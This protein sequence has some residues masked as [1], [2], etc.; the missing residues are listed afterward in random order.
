MQENSKLKEFAERCGLELEKAAKET[1]QNVAKALE[2]AEDLGKRAY[3]IIEKE[4][5]TSR[6]EAKNIATDALNQIR[7]ELPGIR[8]DLEKMEQRIKKRVEDLEKALD[9]LL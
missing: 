7:K 8:R 9:D 4:T 6:T 1:Q 5:R 3:S 2:T